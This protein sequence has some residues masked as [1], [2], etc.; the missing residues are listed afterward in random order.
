MNESLTLPDELSMITD[1]AR[2]RKALLEIGVCWGG[3]AKALRQVMDPKG[4]L[5]LMDPFVKLP[6]TWNN[7]RVYDDE[8]SAHMTV[9]SVERGEVV[10]IKDFSDNAA[11]DF[12]HPLDFLFI[13][14]DH[15]GEQPIKDYRNYSPHIIQGGVLIFHDV[16]VYHPKVRQAF[17]EALKSGKWTLVGAAGSVRVL[18]RK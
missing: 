5:Y 9:E 14:G 2:G 8:A 3:T 7:Q 4:T 1:Y 13:D 15:E 17:E 11:K 12:H 10:W 18:E 6:M 16:A